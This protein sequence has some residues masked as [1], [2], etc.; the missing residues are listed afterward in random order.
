MRCNKKGAVCTATV[1]ADAVVVFN[2][3]NSRFELVWVLWVEGVEGVEGVEDVEDVEGVE[4]VE[5]PDLLRNHRSAVSA[6][7]MM[8]Q[9]L[10]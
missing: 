1:D 6:P 8:R 5:F 7:K 3:M 4:D 9:R 2:L 10:G